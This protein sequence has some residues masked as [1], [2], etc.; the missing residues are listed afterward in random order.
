MRLR[1]EVDEH[2][3]QPDPRA[4]AAPR[5][6]VVVVFPTPPFCVANT[7]RRV[8]SL[9]DYAKLLALQRNFIALS[10]HMIGYLQTRPTDASPSTRRDTRRRRPP[11]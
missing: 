7:V 2:G 3:R 11:A 5:L 10:D 9:D 4:S 8:P 6:S 1:V